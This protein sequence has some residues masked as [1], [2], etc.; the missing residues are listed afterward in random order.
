MSEDKE[1]NLPE[2]EVKETSPVTT[3]EDATTLEKT[4]EELPVADN[5]SPTTEI[6]EPELEVPE[7]KV[8]EK[9]DDS[10]DKDHS[11]ETVEKPT[12]AEKKDDEDVHGR[13][14]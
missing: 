14:R 10:S 12:K 2:N 3:K 13:N 8:S 1:Q 5:E 6:P 11:P 4:T 7:E 9:I